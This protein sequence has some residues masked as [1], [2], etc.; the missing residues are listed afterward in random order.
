V[1]SR[2][3]LPTLYLETF[4]KWWNLQ[5]CWELMIGSKK[6]ERKENGVFMNKNKEFIEKLG[7]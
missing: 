3:H 7:L 5:H 1:K 4:G 2:A 6:N